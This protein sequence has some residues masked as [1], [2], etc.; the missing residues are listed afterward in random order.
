MYNQRYVKDKGCS[1]KNQLI[2]TWRFINDLSIIISIFSKDFMQCVIGI[3]NVYKMQ[4]LWIVNFKILMVAPEA[5]IELL[6]LFCK[7]ALLI[8]SISVLSCRY[9]HFDNS[10]LLFSCWAWLLVA[11]H[12]TGPGYMTLQRRSRGQLM[13]GEATFQQELQKWKLEPFQKSCS[14]HTFGCEP[15][16]LPNSSDVMFSLV[17]WRD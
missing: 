15:L 11:R 17:I 8:L 16:G 2:L 3:F 10:Y 1:W 12:G 4:T 6:A 14:F 13:E 5:H 9:F 7:L